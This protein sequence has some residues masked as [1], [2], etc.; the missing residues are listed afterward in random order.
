MT[1]NDLIDLIIQGVGYFLNSNF[2]YIITKPPK[3]E[4]LDN[5]IPNIRI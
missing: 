1:K 4:S 3:S 2:Q 5:F